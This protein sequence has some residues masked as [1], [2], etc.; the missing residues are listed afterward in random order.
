MK[1]FIRK[2]DECY[3]RLNKETGEI[4]KLYE[5]FVVS[6]EHWLK[7]YA[8]FFCMACDNIS[9]QS[10]KLFSI[11]LKYATED[12]GDGN[13]ILTSNPYFKKEIE[14]KGIKSNISKYFTELTE[15]GLLHRICRGTYRFNPQVVYCGSRHNRAELIL[16]I[17]NGIK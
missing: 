11:C 8:N 13:F 7:L 16:N 5:T 10:I 17:K 12:Q 4:E 6:D 1:V 2:E 14:S 3:E 15:A 9:G